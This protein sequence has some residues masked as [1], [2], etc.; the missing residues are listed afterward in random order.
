VLDRADRSFSAGPL[1]NHFVSTSD[2]NVTWNVTWVTSGGSSIG[3]NGRIF[4]GL[5]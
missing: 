4:R 3:C 1:G 2:D 5:G